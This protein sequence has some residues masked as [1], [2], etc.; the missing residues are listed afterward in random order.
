MR[1]QHRLNSAA[2]LIL[3][4]VCGGTSASVHTNTSP[5]TTTLLVDTTDT[6]NEPWPGNQW[7]Q[8]LYAKDPNNPFV[9]IVESTT[10]HSTLP[11]RFQSPPSS[12]STTTSTTTTTTG[13]NQT[14]YEKSSSSSSSSSSPPIQTTVSPFRNF[15]NYINSFLISNSFAQWLVDRF[16]IDGAHYSM[17]YLRNFLSGT[18]LYYI[19]GSTFHYINYI[20]DSRKLFIPNGGTRQLPEW[21]VIQ[22]QIILSQCSLFLYVALPVFADFLVD[23]G[24]T[25]TYYNVTELGDNCWYFYLLLTLVYFVFVEIGIYWMHRTLHTNKTL[26]KYIHARHHSYDSAETLSP[27]ASIAFHPLDGILQ[28]SPYVVGLF[29]I[30]THYLTHLVLLF[31]TEFWAT[32]IHDT[33]DSDLE[34]IM[35]NKYHT[36]HHTHYMVNYGQ[37]FIFCDWYWGTLQK[38]LHKTGHWI[39]KKKQ[40]IPTHWNKSKDT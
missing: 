13:S 16:G 11:S 35:G 20:K 34:P 36:L 27:W 14:I 15:N 24:Y 2:I 28:A 38:P 29:V 10:Y 31:F 19:Y 3:L 1:M 39:K 22:D 33:L 40:S 7:R 4:F 18:S 23:E 26:F 6:N 12:S 25:Y 37:V 30:P 5:T 21:S 17:C 9:A 32:Y 8:R